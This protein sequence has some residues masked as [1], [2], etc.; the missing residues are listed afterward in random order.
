MCPYNKEYIL[1]SAWLTR[2]SAWLCC[3]TQSICIYMCSICCISF[4][5]APQSKIFNRMPQYCWGE[6]YINIYHSYPDQDSLKSSR[7]NP[8][9]WVN[10]RAVEAGASHG[11]QRMPNEKARSPRHHPRGCGRAPVNETESSMLKWP[12]CWSVISKFSLHKRNLLCIAKKTDNFW[13]FQN[14]TW[15]KMLKQHI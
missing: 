13:N 1:R 15:L 8:E 5:I 3:Y 7:S 6:L 2:L 10:R 12:S 9:K 14:Q 4:K 11:S